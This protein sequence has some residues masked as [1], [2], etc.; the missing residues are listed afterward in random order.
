M[1][2]LLWTTQAMWHIEADYGAWIDRLQSITSERCCGSC[3]A[4]LLWRYPHIILG[5]HSTAPQIYGP[6]SFTVAIYHDMSYWTICSSFFVWKIM[7]SGLYVRS[8]SL[9][10]FSHKTVYRLAYPNASGALY[11]DIRPGN[12]A[13]LSH[14]TLTIAPVA[15]SC[16]SVVSPI[17]LQVVKKFMKNLLATVS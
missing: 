14:R 4:S 7:L 2:V 15:T 13:V 11:T 10:A 9:M 3:P 1:N 8:K 6:S 5:L 17:S 12:G 16:A